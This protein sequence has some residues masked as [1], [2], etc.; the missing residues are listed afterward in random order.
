MRCIQRSLTAAGGTVGTVG[1]V[2]LD[3]VELDVVRSIIRVRDAALEQARLLLQI[4]KVL[5]QCKT[6]ALNK[7]AVEVA[8]NEKPVHDRA[9]VGQR[10]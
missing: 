7:T 6:D 1:T 2:G 8:L 10:S 9:D 3:E 5:G 4:V